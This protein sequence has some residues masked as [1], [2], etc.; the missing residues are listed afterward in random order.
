MY[1]SFAAATLSFTR[2]GDHQ[3]TD[4]YSLII[5]ILFTGNMSSSKVF[6]YMS[7]L[8]KKFRPFIQNVFPPSF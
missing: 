1:I 3:A 6:G 8:V 2:L 7:A 4:R 5:H